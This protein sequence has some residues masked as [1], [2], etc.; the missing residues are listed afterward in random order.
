VTQHRADLGHPALTAHPGHQTAQGSG[1]TDP[2]AGAALLEAA[3]I[4]ELHPEPAG[5]EPDDR[6][7]QHMSDVTGAVPGRF[8]AR[9]G[10]EREDRLGTVS[11]IGLTAGRSLQLQRIE[12]S[13]DV[14]APLRQ[15]KTGVGSRH[16][17]VT[18]QK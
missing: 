6:V 12:I 3:V 7:E 18:P 13:G 1:S 5:I 11:A 16:G 10:V 2:A 14:T 17:V 9:G 4:D 8:A 15:N